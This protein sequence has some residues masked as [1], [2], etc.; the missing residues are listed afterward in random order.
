MDKKC[1]NKGQLINGY[2]LLTKSEIKIALQLLPETE[3]RE[4]VFNVTRKYDDGIL[5]NIERK[6]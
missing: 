4:R 6:R 2:N 3:C 1:Q 5:R